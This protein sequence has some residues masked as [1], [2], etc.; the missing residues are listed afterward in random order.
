M[1]AIRKNQQFMMCSGGT[2]RLLSAAVQRCWRHGEPSLAGELLYRLLETKMVGAHDKTD[3]VAM[4][5]APEA[6]KKPF[7]LDDEK[8][9]GFLIV[10]WT[11]PSEFPPEPH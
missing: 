9:R 1:Q 8:G 11:E 6:V 5:T 2:S 10:E 4:R 7:V 3:C